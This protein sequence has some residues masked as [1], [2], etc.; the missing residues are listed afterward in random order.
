M[1]T[2]GRKAGKS[3]SP[4]NETKSDKFVRLAQARTSKVL[5]NIRQIG[6]LSGANYESA[7]SQVNKIFKAISDAS[8]V[9]FTKFQS[10]GTKEEKEG[11]TL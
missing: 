11:F 10:K 3:V 9:A 4:S 7:D 6:Q 8:Q 1:A 5:N 2:R